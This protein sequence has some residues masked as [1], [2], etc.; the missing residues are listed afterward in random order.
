LFEVF[1]AALQRNAPDF[2]KNALPQDLT[3]PWGDAIPVY[4]ASQH[5]TPGGTS[6]PLR[7]RVVFFGDSITQLPSWVTSL[8]S[9]WSRKADVYNRGYSGYNTSNAIRIVDQAVISLRPDLVG[10]FYGANDA[11]AEGYQSVGI[12]DYEANLRNIVSK[13]QV[14]LP[15]VTIFLITPPPIWEPTL[16]EYYTWGAS[17]SNE[18]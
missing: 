10:I 4:N 5:V 17:R 11:A 13:I 8:A 16:I 15:N 2:V 18:R 12:A 7:K 3:D 9:Y 1:V 14:A 6:L